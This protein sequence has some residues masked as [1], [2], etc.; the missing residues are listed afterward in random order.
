MA[1]ATGPRYIVPLKRRRKK[2]TDYAK[3]VDLLKSNKPRM[4]VRKSGLHIL[5]QIAS[6][7]NEG[8]K[9]IAQ[10]SSKELGKY[11]WPDKCNTPSAYLAGYLCG[12]KA[13]KAKI[14]AA[15]LDAG[16]QTIT[17]GNIIFAAVKGAQDAGVDIPMGEGMI[18]EDRLNGTHI[19]EYAKSIKGTEKYDKQFSA[20]LKAKIK[21]EELPELFEK[22]KKELGG[23]NV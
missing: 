10:V 7:S 2:L 6:P 13:L 22:V 23:S 4:I 20:Y 9:I 18:S 21:P 19:A 17:A 5:V 15:I 3:R 14:N 8:D 16:L 11:K 1:R 12:K